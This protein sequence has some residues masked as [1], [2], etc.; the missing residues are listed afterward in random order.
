ME[1]IEL[2]LSQFTYAQKLELLETIYDDLS[3]DETAFE[4]PAWHEN[5]LNERREAISAGTAQH[6]DWSEP[7]ERINRNPFMRK[8]F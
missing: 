1:K 3:R 8:H 4:S 6:S 7:K 2:P 5:I